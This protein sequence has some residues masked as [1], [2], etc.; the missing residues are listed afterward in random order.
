MICYADTQFNQ[1]TNEIQMKNLILQ[2]SIS[3]PD[4]NLDGVKGVLIDLDDTLYFY[5][6]PHKKAMRVLYEDVVKHF[7]KISLQEFVEQ[8]EDIWTNFCKETDFSILIHNRMVTFQRFAERN[9]IDKPYA[10]AARMKRVYFNAFMRAAEEQGPALQ[11]KKFLE[12]CKK[13]KIP[14]CLMTDMY[15]TTQV[16]K[17]KALKLTSYVDFISSNDE[18]GFD[19]PNSWIF[20]IALN[21]LKLKA[22]DVIMVGNDIERD[23]EGAKNLGIL[24]YHVVVH[25]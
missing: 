1:T 4:I 19:K 5:L 15:A 6:P 3:F 14:V 21:K 9:K 20:E 22:K 11:A 12:R 18:A 13:Q 2:D 23:I 7:C 8:I 10:L 17:L 25:K 24:T 16:R